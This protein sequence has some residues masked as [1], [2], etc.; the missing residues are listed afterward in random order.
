MTVSWHHATLVYANGVSS[1]HAET[2]L[3]PLTVNGVV[4]RDCGIIP[5]A[6]GDVIVFGDPVCHYIMKL[7]PVVAAG[8]SDGGGVTEGNGGKVVRTLKAGDVAA[9]HI[10]DNR[11]ARDGDEVW[12]VEGGKG[13]AG[14]KRRVPEW[15]FASSCERILKSTS[16]EIQ[17]FIP[18]HDRPTL[19]TETLTPFTHDIEPSG[20]RRRACLPTLSHAMHSRPS[21]V[22]NVNLNVHNPGDYPPPDATHA[23]VSVRRVVG[24]WKDQKLMNWRDLQ[25]YTCRKSRGMNKRLWSRLEKSM[26][27]T[28]RVQVSSL[29]H[30]FNMSTYQILG[31][32]TTASE[33]EV[34][35]PPGRHSQAEVDPPRP[36]REYK[37]GEDM[38]SED[39]NEEDDEQ[40]EEVEEDDKDE[41]DDEEDD[42][43]YEEDKDKAKDDDACAPPTCPQRHHPTILIAYYGRAFLSVEVA[44]SQST[45]AATLHVIKEAFQAHGGSGSEAVY[46]VLDPCPDHWRFLLSVQSLRGC[47][48]A[49]FR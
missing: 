26:R 45:T 17:V 15:E 7:E 43:D 42:D 22:T 23:H 48:A 46:C 12:E 41:E 21:A 4:V 2:P 29:F 31:I 3:N 28:A 5:L 49:I 14:G 1:I 38:D 18:L 44:H 34:P 20:F 10:E 39:A 11:D 27:A 36:E 6:H 32:P 37:E 8:K 33:E 47:K 16:R 19:L 9:P 13:V 30:L 24:L 35:K 25:L 40:N